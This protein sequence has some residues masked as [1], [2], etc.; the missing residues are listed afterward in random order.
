MS[1]AKQQ[2]FVEEYLIDLNATQAAIRAGYSKKTAGQIG[3][4]L[5]KKPETQAA[6]DEAMK[7]RS[8]RTK[9]T[10]DAVMTE[11]AKLG[12][13]NMLDY[14][15]VSDGGLGFLDLSAVTRDQAAA[16]VE[17]TTEE[18]SGGRDADGEDGPPILKTKIKLADKRAALVDL[19]KHLG[20]FVSRSE[21][22]VTH[23]RRP[24]DMTR[25]A[26]EAEIAK[27]SDGTE[28]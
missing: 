21:I 26:V 18:V 28:H 17:M 24:R 11:L 9:I 13:A 14:V 23:N 5:L 4:E 12:F 15:R 27:L 16:I 7:A 8:E 3:H 20:M 19:G 22:D 10:A 6:I 1:D 2:R 25:A